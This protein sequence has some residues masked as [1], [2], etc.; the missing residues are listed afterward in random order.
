MSRQELVAATRGMAGMSE[1]SICRKLKKS[2]IRTDEQKGHMARFKH[3]KPPI[4]LEMLRSTVE[5][6]KN[7]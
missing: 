2:V 4:H 7:Y 3:V 6:L 5:F 1:P